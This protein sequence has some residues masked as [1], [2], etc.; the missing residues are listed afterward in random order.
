M[1]LRVVKYKKGWICEYKK[2]KFSLFKPSYMWVHITSYSG[3]ENIP[4]YYKDGESAIK[5]AATH[6]KFL[7][8]YSY[9]YDIN[10][11]K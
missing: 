9:K 10:Y 11:R 6:V 5:G 4:F 7:L 2:Y 3:L 8:N 1:E